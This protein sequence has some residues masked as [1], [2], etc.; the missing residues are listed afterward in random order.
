LPLRT[1]PDLCGQRWRVCFLDDPPWE[2][3]E[4]DERN[5]LVV[6]NDLEALA[7]V[8][9]ASFLRDCRCMEHPL[10]ELR[11]LESGESERMRELPRSTK[12]C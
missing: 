8:R 7:A 3:E 4:R 6:F 1:G 2:Y 12:T 9:F 5:L 10:A 11:A